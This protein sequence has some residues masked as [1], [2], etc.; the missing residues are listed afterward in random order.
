MI[1]RLVLRAINL[2]VA[3]LAIYAFFRVPIGRRTGWAH[4][5]A[6]FSTTPAREAAQDVR[7][8]AV[9]VGRQVV[10]ETTRAIRAIRD[11]G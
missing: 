5:V 7:D 2:V 10:D 11:G 4:A 3:L 8:T 1:G 9:D 6:I